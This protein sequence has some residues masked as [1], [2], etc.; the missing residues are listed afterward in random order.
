MAKDKKIV[1]T[2]AMVYSATALGVHIVR[3]MATSVLERQPGTT[4]SAFMDILTAHEAK[5][6]ESQ[7]VKT[8]V[9][10]S[11]ETPDVIQL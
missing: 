4:L 9:Q 8:T 11:S 7:T 1:L 3:E 2:E 6:K 10:D 5:I